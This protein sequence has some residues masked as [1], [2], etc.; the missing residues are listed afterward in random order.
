MISDWYRAR[1]NTFVNGYLAMDGAQQSGGSCDNDVHEI[2]KCLGEIA[3]TSA[4]VVENDDGSLETWNC[5][6]APGPLG[7]ITATPAEPV[8]TRIHINL[9]TPREV[10]VN[11]TAGPLTAR[12]KTGMQWLGSEHN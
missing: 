12:C 11:F 2:F 6:A 10:R 1:P 7:T 4:Y 8:V 9:K 3:L 5:K